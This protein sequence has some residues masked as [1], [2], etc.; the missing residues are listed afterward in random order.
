[1]RF[2]LENDKYRLE[3]ESLGAE[4]KS[5]QKKED[6]QEYLWSGDPAYWNGVSPLLFPFIGVL[7]EG[8]YIYH[9]KHYSME[10]HGFARMAQFTAVCEEQDRLVLEITDTPHTMEGYPFAFRLEVEYLLTDRGVKEIWR[11]Y[12]RGSETMYFSIGGHPALSCPPPASQKENM[13]RTFCFIKLLGA[14]QRREVS[15]LCVIPGGLL[16]GKTVPVEVNNGMVAIT[17]TLFSIDTILLQE[18]IHGAALCDAKGREYVRVESDAPVW[19]IW[20][21]E[22]SRAAYICLEPWFGLCDYA[23]FQGS[24]EERPFTNSVQPGGVWE[25]GFD[26]ILDL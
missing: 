14:E 17:D 19:G 13:D 6:G 23:S 1:M 3:V 20:S 16:S 22:D 7:N 18:Q 15:S 9:G 10:R 21:K 11:V 12:N 5:L 4:M 26:I 2:I 25:A 8:K 24:L